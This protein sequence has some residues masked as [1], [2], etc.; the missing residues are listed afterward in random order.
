VWDC[1][2]I[3]ICR[4]ELAAFRLLIYATIETAG[5]WNVTP[6]SLAEDCQSFG[7]TYCHH[8]EGQRVCQ[9]IIII[10]IIIIIVYS[11]HRSITGI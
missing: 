10:I 11:F 4:Q 7:G 2:A 1:D 8:F 5:F 3:Y 6:W 9:V